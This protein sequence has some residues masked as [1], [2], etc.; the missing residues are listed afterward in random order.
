MDGEFPGQL[1]PPQELLD[2]SGP[3]HQGGLFGTVRPP[4]SPNLLAQRF[5]QRVGLKAGEDVGGELTE[6]GALGVQHLVPNVQGLGDRES[7]EDVRALLVSFL[8]EE[9]AQNLRLGGLG[10]GKPAGPALDS[11]NVRPAVEHAPQPVV[12]VGEWPQRHFHVRPI[13]EVKAKDPEHRLHHGRHRLLGLL[14]LPTHQPLLEQSLEVGDAGL[15]IPVHVQVAPQRRVF[16]G[17]HEVQHEVLK[18]VFVA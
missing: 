1:D 12:E 14:V 3:Q 16:A 13:A 5:V 2:P 17:L 7:E 8:E 15:D 9:A 4:V 6:E 18:H 10:E 11:G